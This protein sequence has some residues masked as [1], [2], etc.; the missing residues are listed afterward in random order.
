V[1]APWAIVC[2]FDGTA[3]TEDLGDLVARRYS[4]EEAWSAAEERFR[5]GLVTFGGLI[6]EIFT[7]IRVEQPELQA[8][9]RARAVW[10]PG[11]ERFLS[12]C[13]AGGIPFLLVSSGLDL[14]IE[15]VLERLP[16]ALRAHL[17]LR[18]NRAVLTPAGARLTFFGADC[19]ACGA[20]KGHVVRELQGRGHKVVV[21]GD[22]TGDRHAADAADHVFARAGSSLARAC[23]RDGLAHDVFATFDEVMERFPA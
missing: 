5:A 16:P 19:G 6:E 21:L 9:A 20:C 11:F 12:A 18:S 22:G 2:D 8:F 15:P 13:A 10:R 7:A 23:A 4:S 14:Y 3:L 1:R 17:E